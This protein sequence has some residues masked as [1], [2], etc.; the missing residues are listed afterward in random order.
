[1][2][3]REAACLS[4]KAFRGEKEL[5]RLAP[6][7]EVSQSNVGVVFSD[8]FPFGFSGGFDDEVVIEADLVADRVDEVNDL[9]NCLL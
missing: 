9:C 3:L 2:A 6:V 4:A 8:A 1:V 7:P 5:V